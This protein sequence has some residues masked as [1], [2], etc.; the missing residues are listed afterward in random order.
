MKVEKQNTFTPITITLETQEEV[1]KLYAIFNFGDIT[2]ALQIPNWYRLL[3]PHKLYDEK[4]HTALY[5][6][7]PCKI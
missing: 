1:D 7:F 5:K 4:Y 6:K 3:S 2:D